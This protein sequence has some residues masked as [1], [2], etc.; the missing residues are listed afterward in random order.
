MFQEY[1]R[2]ISGSPEINVLLC[3]SLATCCKL[4]AVSANAVHYLINQASAYI[5]PE[6][7]PIPIPGYSHTVRLGKS[8]VGP[9]SGHESVFQVYDGISYDLIR[10]E[11]IKVIE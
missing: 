2:I 8:T 9:I 5:S 10:T 6:D 4:A 3:L 1:S 11:D 7:T